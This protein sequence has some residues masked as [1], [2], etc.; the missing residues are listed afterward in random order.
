MNKSTPFI[1]FLIL[2]L[3]L[4]L[5]AATAAQPGCG[6]AWG[7]TARVHAKVVRDWKETRFLAENGF[8][9]DGFCAHPT[10]WGCCPAESLRN[11]TLDPA[12]TPCITAVPSSDGTSLYV[13]A[14]RIGEWASL[15]YATVNAGPTSH[16]RCHTLTYDPDAQM[17]SHLFDGLFTPYTEVEGSITIT[18]TASPTG[19]L[20]AG[21]V[22]YK[23]SFVPLTDTVD[24]VS[25]DGLF[26][27]HLQ[28]HSLPAD[29]YVLILPTNAPPGPL[30]FNYTLIGSP[31]AIRASGALTGTEQPGI[32]T[33]HYTA[34][35]L[36]D[37]D[38]QTLRI[39]AWDPAGDR[40][41]D[42]GGTLNERDYSVSVAVTRFT[43]YALLAPQGPIHRAYLPLV[44]KGH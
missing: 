16:D 37:I 34:Q 38:P 9:A 32:L 41:V 17:Y 13:Y 24:L 7:W 2:T 36:G 3:L 15:I 40:W 4:L 21:P 20:T 35:T 10:V 19:T 26:L 22:F 18:T 29:A 1:C 28:D 14:G 23:R 5:P 25:S 44:V 43:T 30:P 12:W 31:Y 27:L 39:H 11:V 6:T 8:L 42:L 33:L